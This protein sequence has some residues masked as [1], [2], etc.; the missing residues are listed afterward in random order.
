VLESQEQIHGSQPHQGSQSHIRSQGPRATGGTSERPRETGGASQVQSQTE[1][2]AQAQTE[3][4]AQPQGLGGF[5]SW[6][7]CSRQD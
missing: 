4:H 1:P 5:A 7:E 3:P 6:F 2:Q